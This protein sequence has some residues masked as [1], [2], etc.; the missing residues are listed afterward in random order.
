MRY[1]EIKDNVVRKVYDGYTVEI[2]NT[3]MEKCFSPDEAIEVIKALSELPTNALSQKEAEL[4]TKLKTER[5]REMVKF[6]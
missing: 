2:H 6:A 5:V 1:F 3:P 4:L